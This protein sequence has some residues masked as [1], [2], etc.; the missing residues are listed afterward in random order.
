M[1]EWKN[2]FNSNVLRQGMEY[3][4]FDKVDDYADDGEKCEASVQDRQRIPVKIIRRSGDNGY[5]MR[6]TCPMARGGGKCKHMAAVLYAMEAKEKEHLEAKTE[7]EEQKKAGRRA[8]S[9]KTESENSENRQITLDEIMAEKP[10]AEQVETEQVET[11]Q[12]ET[13]EPEDFS[14]EQDGEYI[15]LN[16]QEVL[17]QEEKAGAGLE[18]YAAL[19]HYQYFDGEQIQKSMNLTKAIRQRG[20]KLL[21]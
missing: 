2:Q 5:L 6:C 1:R 3:Y 12:P 7:P 8:K 16:R 21:L 20:E 4:A 15:V 14:G 19:S 10:E 11:E 18:A 17:P 9:R 13:I